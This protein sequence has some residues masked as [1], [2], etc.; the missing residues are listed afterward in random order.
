M[1][2]RRRFSSPE[3]CTSARV[4]LNRF[5]SEQHRQKKKMHSPLRQSHYLRDCLLNSKK[6]NTQIKKERY[7]SKRDEILLQA[8]Q[9][10]RARQ[11]ATTE[12]K[13]SLSSKLSRVVSERSFAPNA[14]GDAPDDKND[15]TF[16]AD[17]DE[18]IYTTTTTTTRERKKLSPRARR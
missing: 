12:S 7:K 8:S 18:K 2:A 9:R 1:N 4:R 17:P 10:A 5:R 11:S 14:N 15:I 16:R 13:T 6:S 3:L